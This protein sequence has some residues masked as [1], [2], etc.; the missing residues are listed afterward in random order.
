M[1]KIFGPKY[2]YYVLGILTLTSMLNI[3][4]RLVFSILME[5]IKQEYTMSDT[6]LALLAGFAFALFYAT[7]GIPIAR[8]AD[9]SNRKNIIAISL[10]VWSTMT[11]LCGAAIGFW[12]L[13]LARMGVG[14]GEA[15]GS[16]PSYSMIADYFKP[17]ERTW[18]MGIYI[19]G[20]VLGTSAGLIVGGALAD[21]IGWRWTFVALGVPGVLLGLVLYLT[22]QEP[23]RG[24]ND[25]NGEQDAKAVEI[26]ATLKSLMGNKVYVR[27]SLCYALITTI[28]YAIA[29]WLAPLML[30]NYDVSTAMVG[31][32]LGG[33]FLVGGIPGPIVGGYVTE[34]L[35]KRNPKWRAW[36]PAIA[37]LVCFAAYCFSLTAT[38]FAG[39][40]GFFIFG[41][42]VFMMPQ[43]PTLS[44]MQDALKPGERALGVSFALF[45]NNILGQ[46][47]GLF[48]VGYLSDKMM[49]TF[50]VKSLN[51][52]IIILS[53]IAAVLGCIMYMRTAAA[54][55]G[56]RW[57]ADLD[58]P[59]KT[60]TDG[61]VENG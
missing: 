7:L 20:A 28:G 23:K 41:Y 35:V 24:I 50:G 31:L 46:V 47:V 42:F 16:P 19:T 51:Y 17:S 60:P 15:G 9:K 54:M 27:I 26:G 37:I 49:P 5:D 22:V 13:F 52:A 1:K 57:Q 53:A 29:V 11:A 40:I 44:L 32:I 39:F 58:D 36:M 18:A 4:D 55:T 33:S 61:V 45:V 3:A 43:G 2:R 10:T 34:R 25:L 30:R 56:S 12:S 59:T 21:A 8:L 6:Q 14:A 38:T 48:V